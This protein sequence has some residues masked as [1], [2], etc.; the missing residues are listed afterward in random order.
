MASDFA[1]TAA[2]D[3][4]NIQ[5]GGTSFFEDAGNLVTKGVGGAVVS[6]L[7]SIYNTGVDFSNKFFGTDKERADTAEILNNVDRDWGTYYE[8]HKD[9]ID[10]AGFFAGSLI[11]GTIAVKGLKLAQAGVMGGSFKNVLGFAS[12]REAITLNAALT[13]LETAG[14]TVFQRISQNKLA[15][16][17]WGTADNILQVAAFETATALTM[18]A[19][20]MLDKEDWGTI[21]WDVTK[22]SLGGGVLGG[23]LQALMTNKL[24]KD[25]GKLV[26]SKMRMAD[27]LKDVGQ[28]DLSFGDR[29]FAIADAA[30][31]VPKEGVD[32]I[33]KLNHGRADLKQSLDV[34]ELLDRTKRESVRRALVKLEG[35][36]TNTVK[37]DP[38]VGAP[39]ARA[40]LGIVKEGLETGAPPEAMKAKLGDYLFNLHSVEGIGNKGL[41][42]NG[43]IRWLNTKASVLDKE[44]KLFPAEKIE[45][46]IPYRIVGD[47]NQARQAVLGKEVLNPQDAWKLGYDSVLDPVS[48]RLQ[49]SPT[50]AIYQKVGDAEAELSSMFLNVHTGQT[51]FNA[52]PTIAD[53]QT[54]KAPLTV[55]GKLRGVTLQGVQAGDKTYKFSFE[56]Y[57]RPVDSVEATARHLWADNLPKVFGKVDSEDIAVLEVLA[58]HP[59]RAAPDL[60]IVDRATGASKNFADIHDPKTYVFTQKKATL[61]REFG[62]LAD[63]TDI[64]ELAYRVNSSPEWVDL[65]VGTRLDDKALYQHMGWQQDAARYGARENLIMR[66]NTKG[67][68]DAANSP[69]GIVAYEQRVKEATERAKIGSKTV[70]GEDHGLLIDVRESLAGTADSLNVGAS[71]FGASNAGYADRLR[72]WGQYTGQIVSNVVNKRVSAVLSTLQAPAARVQASPKAA[73]EL[74]ATMT[75]ARLSTDSWAIYTDGFSGNKMLVDLKSYDAWKNKGQPPLFE[76]RIELTKEAGDFLQAHHDAYAT[77]LDQERVLASSVGK[78]LRHNPDKLYMPPVDTQRLPFFAFVRQADGTMFGSDEVAMIT[79]RSSAELDRLAGEV[80]KN[81]QLQVIYKKDTEIYHKAKADYDFSRTM[82]NPVIEPTLRKQG[83]LGDYLP[84]MT[85]EAVIEDFVQYHQR[86]ETKLVRDAVSANYAQSIAELKDLSERYTASQTSKFEGLS[87]LLQRNVQDPFGDAIKLAMNISKRGEFTLWHQANEFVDALGTKAFRGIEKAA[88]E[89]RGGKIG[90][91]EANATMERFG[92]GTPYKDAEAFAVAQTASDRNLIK[93][94][95]QKANML[96]STGM[97]RLDFANSLLNIISTPILLGTEVSALRN[98]IKNDPELFA[99]FNSL[100]SQK[101]PGSEVSIPSATRL[102]FN[103]VGNAFGDQGKALM[104][105]Y[106]EIGAVKGQAAIFHEMMNDLSLTPKL[107]PSEF[108]KKVDSWVEKGATLTFSNHAEDYTRFVSANVMHQITQPLVDAAKMTPQEQNAFISIF[109]NRVQGNYVASQRP[110]L[111]QGTLGSAIGLFQTYQFNMFQQLFRH[112]ENKDMKTIAVMGAM[113]GTLFGANGLPLFEAI[114]THLVGGASIN[115]GH[116]DAYS[117]AVKAVGKEYGDWLMYGTASAF[118]LWSEKAPALWT[119]GDLNPRSAFIVPT[120]PMDVPAVSASIKVVGNVLNMAKQMGNGADATDA[121]L[122]GLEHNGINRP[123]T[124]LAQVMKGNAT[125]TKGDLISASQDWDGIA[126][127]ARLIGAK[128]MDESLAIST[129][130]RSRAYAAMDKERVDAIGS[131]IKDKLRNNQQLSSEDWVD[132]QGRYAAAGGRIEGFAQAVQRWDR[133]ANTSLANEVMRHSQTPA[134]KRMIEVLGGTP[135]EDYRNTPPNE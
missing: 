95:L 32:A 38:T 45:G 110:I 94:T 8:D 63:K 96:L 10:T 60:Q 24:V 14:G 44:A 67:M 73:A 42:L 70:L 64:R 102:I 30:I 75:K 115:E 83:L 26:D 108:A 1:F 17:A 132:M 58:K 89:A 128:P 31:S 21:F 135:L 20:P 28:V 97:L 119:R 87:K 25:A 74:A 78:E 121:L 86:A 34:S 41:D 129:M 104:T 98:S 116:N 61:E 120:S 100:L 55:D 122:F 109:V 88:L 37:T 36:I 131:V 80:L 47:E 68:Q 3:T 111:F 46:G 91:E 126:T 133:V 23:G 59:E 6:G 85:P 105:R 90:W 29:A 124:G 93:T 35:E 114:N 52:V 19:S 16:M 123:L 69:Q 54:L 113:Q 39:L 82:N 81:P 130:Y 107:V 15:S 99:S 118:P 18:K 77:R 7:A 134:G 50:S 65:A 12:T 5:A 117:Y 27:V 40:M 127:A 9:V 84:N 53:V 106:R 33:I 13:E 103:A 2:T 71:T 112:I 79:A 76:K 92:L 49:I 57:S 43:E 125:S 22:T 4:A 56:K 62:M 101:V 51:S 11:P 66:Y 72:S 48:G